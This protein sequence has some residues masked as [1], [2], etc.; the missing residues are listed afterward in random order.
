M[1]IERRIKINDSNYLL[2]VK[3]K[4]NNK[5]HLVRDDGSYFDLGDFN[6]MIEY[7]EKHYQKGLIYDKSTIYMNDIIYLYDRFPYVSYI[8]DITY[9][10][11][12]NSIYQ[13]GHIDKQEI[14][15]YIKIKNIE[16]NRWDKTK[17]ICPLLYK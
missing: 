9:S 5:G 17:C 1:I 12:D 10:K 15:D 2:G 11:Q 6:L 13:I 3:L 16:I 4:Y 8:K 14:L 7:V